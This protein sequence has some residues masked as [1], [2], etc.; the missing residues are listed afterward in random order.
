MGNCQTSHRSNLCHDQITETEFKFLSNSS[1]MDILAPAVI[2]ALEDQ[3]TSG[4]TDVVDEFETDSRQAILKV[5]QCL[6]TDAR[7]DSKQTYEIR[8]IRQDSI[9]GDLPTM[10]RGRLST[11]VGK[12]WRYKGETVEGKANGF[13][14]YEDEDGSKYEG[15]WKDNRAHGIGRYTRKDGSWYSGDWDN[16]MQHGHGE[17]NWPDGS[18]YEGAYVRGLKTGQGK[19]T[20]ADGS[21]Y[22]GELRDNLAHGFGEHVWAADKR[23]YVG[24]WFRNKMHGW[25]RMEWPDGSVYDGEFCEDHRHGYGRFVWNNGVSF[26]GFWENRLQHGRGVMVDAE[27]RRKRGTWQKGA[28][29]SS[30]KTQSIVDSDEEQDSVLMK[31]RLEKLQT[32]DKD[33]EPIAGE[34]Q[35]T[36]DDG[37]GHFLRHSQSSNSINSE[38][39]ASLL[40]RPQFS[41]LD[42]E[43]EP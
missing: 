34:R 23:R 11:S 9:V 22:K 19:F 8:T 18:R 33:S 32:G 27:G 43:F 29:A 39:L 31:R 6:A 4:G 35:S 17:E 26:V 30:L 3:S 1:R 5:D 2:Y 25:G 12:T 37:L 10:S 28:L 36:F 15:S 14:V 7:Q 24:D 16:N 41:H 38:F 13:G 21:Y 40:Q 20:W 42:S